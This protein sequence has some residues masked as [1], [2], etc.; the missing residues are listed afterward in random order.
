M[1]R[2]FPQVNPILAGI[3]EC[4][5]TMFRLTGNVI[6][7]VKPSKGQAAANEINVTVDG[8]GE[9]TIQGLLPALAIRRTL[10]YPWPETGSASQP[11]PLVRG[12]S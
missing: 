7:F 2:P 12:I 3:D 10:T 1:P 9:L 5:R 4:R 8:A 6:F 11:S